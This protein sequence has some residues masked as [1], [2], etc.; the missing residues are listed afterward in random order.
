MNVEVTGMEKIEE[1]IG[2]IAQKMEPD[3]VEGV[4]LTHANILQQAVITNAPLGPTGN[5]KRGIVSK[6]MQRRG[7]KY[8]PALVAIDYRIAPHAH[9]VEFGHIIERTRR[10]KSFGIVPPHPF[11]RPA[12]DSQR[13]SMKVAIEEEIK[14][15]IEGA[16]TP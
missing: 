5:L 14:S 2:K 12:W 16:P 13:E 3:V 4:L 9:L 6:V 1:N 15:N 8:A 11:F 7:N 10:G